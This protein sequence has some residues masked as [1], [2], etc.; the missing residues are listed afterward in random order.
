MADIEGE[1]L[2]ALTCIDEGEE[3]EVGMPVAEEMGLL[4]ADDDE[5]AAAEGADEEGP[6]EAEDCEAA[7]LANWSPNRC[8]ASATPGIEL[9]SSP[10][11]WSTSAT[12]ED[13][14]LLGTEPAV[15]T[16]DVDDEGLSDEAE[17]DV[18]ILLCDVEELL[19]EV[20]EAG[21]EEG[22]APREAARALP[23]DAP[24]LLA[25]PAEDM[26]PEEGE[27]TPRMG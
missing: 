1:A 18:V 21:P 26:R 19:L 11:R 25:L 6:V 3:D 20:S 22:V 5:G 8:M 12:D 9:H 23:V 13:D 10:K 17:C 7:F 2:L 24:L 16:C 14:V 27:V 15:E 4:G